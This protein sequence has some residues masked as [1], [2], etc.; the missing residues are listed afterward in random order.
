[1]SIPENT[2]FAQKNRLMTQIWPK[3]GAVGKISD[4]QPDG[5]GFK[6]GLTEGRALGDLNSPHR[7]W[8]EGR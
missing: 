1:M 2:V 6:A 3:F 7:P 5:P 8:T 4:R